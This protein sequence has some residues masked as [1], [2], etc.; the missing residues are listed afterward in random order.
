[1]LF[2]SSGNIRGLV[3]FIKSQGDSIVKEGVNLDYYLV[4]GKGIS[5]YLK[6][7]KAIRKQIKNDD[8]DVIHAHYG[9]IGLICMLT[10]TKPPVVLSIMGS[11]AYGNFNEKG[12][13]KRTSYLDMILTQVALLF[14]RQ[15]IVK[16]NNLL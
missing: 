16:S 1:M 7:I 14:A 9:L 8:Y 6:N 12:Q 13:R 3:P 4:Y 2:V 10:F 15:V 5:G 11:D